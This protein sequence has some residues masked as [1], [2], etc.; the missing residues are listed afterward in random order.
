MCIR[1][2]A[3]GLLKRAGAAPAPA[4]SQDLAKKKAMLK[5]LAA[6]RAAAKQNAV[7]PAPAAP[8]WNA[9]RAAQLAQAVQEESESESESDQ[10]SEPDHKR[11]KAEGLPSGF[12]DAGEE[13]DQPPQQQQVRHQEEEDEEEAPASALPAGFFDDKQLDQ[14]AQ[15]RDMEAEMQEKLKSFEESMKN[16]HFEATLREATGERETKE[17]KELE[18]ETSEYLDETITE[19]IGLLSKVQSLRARHK[20]S[21]KT[22][23][24]KKQAAVVQEEEDHEEMDLEALLAGDDWRTKDGAAGMEF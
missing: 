17:Q 11:Q 10:E 18:Q 3:R 24:P 1:D 22:K 16:E 4:K 14:K 5:A 21:A 23:V 20:P 8:S 9:A 2:R 19:Q 6:K 7:S 13:E 15:G 12:F